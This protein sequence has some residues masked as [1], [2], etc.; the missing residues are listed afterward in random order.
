MR[1][2]TACDDARRRVQVQPG[3]AAEEELWAHD[4]QLLHEAAREPGVPPGALGLR[5]PPPLLGARAPR[6]VARTT[7][8]RAGGRDLPQGHLPEEKCGGAGLPLAHRAPREGGD[9][10]HPRRHAAL[11]RLPQRPA[12]L[13]CCD[14]RRKGPQSALS[15]RTARCR[16][17]ISAFSKT[18]QSTLVIIE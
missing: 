7:T 2:P 15:A 11:L 10:R 8:R 6:R 17:V 12:R 14:P 13:L 4:Q 16:Y 5:R 9:G 3:L 1:G 18:V